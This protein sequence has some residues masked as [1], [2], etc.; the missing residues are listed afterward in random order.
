[1]LTIK[2]YIRPETMEEAYNLCQKRSNVVLG[3]ML[4]LKLSNRNVVNAIDLCNLGL[5]WITEEEDCYRIGAMVSL[6]TLEMHE[7]LNRMTQG[8]FKEALRHIVGV[9]FR[10]VA[11]LGGS[12][13]GRFGFSDVYTLLQV[14]EAKVCLYKQGELSLDE[15]AL[16][17]RKTKDILT[18]IIIPKKPRKVAYLSQRNT[19]TDFPALACAVCETEDNILCAVGARPSLASLVKEDKEIFKDGITEESAVIFGNKVADSFKFDSNLR[20]SKEYRKKVCSVL[21][22]RGI[23]SFVEV[24]Y[25]D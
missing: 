20:G 7:E 15:F 19:K 8:E 4:W 6:R 1:M 2:N 21:V 11:T 23:M 10:N 12:V 22:K 16:I 9:Q 14:L 18:E 3:G 13:Y 17:P 5:D 24:D 25:A